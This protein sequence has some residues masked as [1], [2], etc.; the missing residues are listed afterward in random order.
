[1]AQ[2]KGGVVSVTD[3]SITQAKAFTELGLGLTVCMTGCSGLAGMLQT[4][5]HK[6][7]GKPNLI[8]LSGLDR[9]VSASDARPIYAQP[10][11]L[12]GYDN[13]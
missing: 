5:E 2:T 10:T 9:T 12:V 6:I 11:R 1:M 7:V 8:I 4:A 3:E 13:G